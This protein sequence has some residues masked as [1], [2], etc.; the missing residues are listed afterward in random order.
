M[1]AGRVHWYLNL[2]TATIQSQLVPFT[3]TVLSALGILPPLFSSSS[4]RDANRR[5]VRSALGCKCSISVTQDIE[6]HR[7]ERMC[8]RTRVRA[9]GDGRVLKKKRQQAYLLATRYQPLHEHRL[10]LLRVVQLLSNLLILQKEE[11]KNPRSMGE[12]VGGRVWRLT[13]G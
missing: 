3:A 11:K 1:Y 4:R 9:L 10:A 6:A 13:Y 5:C 2:T 12:W 8:V 7:R